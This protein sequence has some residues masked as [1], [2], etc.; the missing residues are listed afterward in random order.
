MYGQIH[1]AR[2]EKTLSEGTN[3]CSITLVLI[4]IL[5]FQSGVSNT[6]EHKKVKSF[7]LLPRFVLAMV[8]NAAEMSERHRSVY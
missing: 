4:R 8:N 6:V 7:P 5:S 2:S 1:D 3:F